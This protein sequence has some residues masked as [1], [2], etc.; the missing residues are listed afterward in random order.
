MTALKK[1]GHAWMVFDYFQ[2]AS[3]GSESPRG[4]DIDEALHC[5]FINM[6]SGREKMTESE[7]TI[8]RGTH[9]LKC[10]TD[11]KFKTSGEEKLRNFMRVSV[12][13]V[14]KQKVVCIV[15]EVLKI[16]S[17]MVQVSN[18]NSSRS[19]KMAPEDYCGVL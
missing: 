8:R 3:G 5:L 17:D 1:K 10:N 12:F 7:V 6:S 11:G 19:Q 14:W 16:N 2:V 15:G 18:G 4:N 9:K 13:S